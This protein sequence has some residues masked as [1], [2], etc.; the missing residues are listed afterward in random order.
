MCRTLHT[1][2]T[3]SC[4]SPSRPNNRVIGILS[5][6]PV[7]LDSSGLPQAYSSLPRSFKPLRLWFRNATEVHVVMSTMSLS[8][9]IR[10]R[11]S[12]MPLCP[13][14]P[15]TRTLIT[16]NDLIRHLLASLQ[17]EAQHKKRQNSGCFI[18]LGHRTHTQLPQFKQYFN[19]HL[20]H[21]TQQHTA[22]EMASETYK[23]SQH[24]GTK[25]DGTEDKRYDRA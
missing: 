14:S 24:G 1:D 7:T 15:M 3:R 25:K 5:F 13:T 18:F 2:L 6:W 22:I 11:S 21:S 10:G 16:S 4:S 9:Q 23:P 20:K 12:L 8:C 17:H 19:L